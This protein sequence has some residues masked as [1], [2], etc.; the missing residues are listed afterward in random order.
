SAA[1]GNAGTKTFSFRVWITNPIV[2]AVTFDY[3][4]AD[5]TG[6]GAATVADNDYVA[7]NGSSSIPAGQTQTFIA[8]TVNG[9]A[10]LEQD[11]MF[12]LN[13]TNVSVNANVAD[14][15]GQGTIQNDEGPN[16]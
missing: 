4:T 1:E 2:S 14:P 6:P 16:I 10:T 7:T 12:F 3:A 8:V 13:V 15:Q 9:D 11:E 5:G